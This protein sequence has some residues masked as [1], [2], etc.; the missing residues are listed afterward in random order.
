MGVPEWH[1]QGLKGSSFFPMSHAPTGPTGHEMPK[2]MLHHQVLPMTE[3]TSFVLLEHRAFLYV[4]SSG[5][6]S[7]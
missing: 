7:S 3:S 2:T 1:V 6:A 5:D 4:C